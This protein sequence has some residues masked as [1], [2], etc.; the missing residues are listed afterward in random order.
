LPNTMSQQSKQDQHRTQ[1]EFHVGSHT[2]QE[3][4]LEDSYSQYH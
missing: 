2:P 4:K 3:I 1:Y